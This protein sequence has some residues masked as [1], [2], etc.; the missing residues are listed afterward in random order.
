M[1]VGP[2]RKYCAAVRMRNHNRNYDIWP[3]ELKIGTPVTYAL[4]NV[5]TN[6]VFLRFI[7]F[8]LGARRGQTDGGTD[9]QDA[10]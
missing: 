6:L 8:E 10:Y 3:F 1:S 4:G 7:V 9:R 5:H 2:M